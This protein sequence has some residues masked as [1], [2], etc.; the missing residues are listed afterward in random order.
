[1]SVSCESEL[2]ENT[3][4]E[5]GVWVVG[6]RG[7]G[8]WDF[9]LNA[10]LPPFFFSSTL[11]SRACLCAWCDS[12]MFVKTDQHREDSLLSLFWQKHKVL[13]NIIISTHPFYLSN[14]RCTQ[15]CST[16]SLKPMQKQYYPSFCSTTYNA[17]CVLSHIDF[18]TSCF[19][20]CWGTVLLLSGDICFSMVLMKWMTF[21]N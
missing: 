16:V 4:G 11:H 17:C 10:A 7:E 9:M 1:M 2:K 21:H 19:W 3:R 14:T 6:G 8:V 18:C 20:A 12:E 5:D 15:A 13:W